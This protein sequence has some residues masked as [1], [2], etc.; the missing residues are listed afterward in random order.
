MS[1]HLKAVLFDL[2]GVIVDTAR[3]HYLAW[4]K[5][6]EE[7]GIAF[8]E[9]ANEALKGV[10]RMA[11]LDLILARGKRDYSPSEKIALADKKNALY[12][13]MIAGLKPEEILP[14]VKDFLASLKAAGIKRAICSASKN[15]P[16]ILERLKVAEDFDT[17]VS[18]ND[19]SRSKPD[20]EVFEMAAKRL[21][22]P[23]SEC[24]VVEDAYAGIQ[25]AKSA[26]MKA[27][28]IGEAHVLNIAD[29]VYSST[30]QLSLTAILA[31][32]FN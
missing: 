29:L 5:I 10:S 30:A 9:K 26:G 16:M 31:K 11:S 15:A 14:G 21:G 23:H 1:V 19:T 3:Y 32:L 17:V 4:K 18:G 2:D 13:E 24:L 12:V 28:G 7:Q 22:L 27:V 8:D 6:A 25:A 20:P